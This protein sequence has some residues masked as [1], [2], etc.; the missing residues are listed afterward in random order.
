MQFTGNTTEKMRDYMKENAETKVRADLVLD[1]IAKA[2]NIE[3]SDEEVKDKALELAKM[4]TA[5]EHEKMAD[6]L[7]KTQKSMIEREIIMTKTIKV[8]TDNVK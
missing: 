4:Y 8:L 3:A 1:A 5:S 7:A 2:E 6:M